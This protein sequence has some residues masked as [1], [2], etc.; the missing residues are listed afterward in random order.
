MKRK[1]LVRFELLVLAAVTLLLA[2]RVLE[3]PPSPSGI[4]VYDDLERDDLRRESFSIDAPVRVAIEAIGSFETGDDDDEPRLAA[5]G[6]LLNRLDRTVAWKLDPERAHRDRNTLAVTMDTVLLAPGTYDTY[7]TSY[8]NQRSGGFNFRLFDTIFGE[9]QAWKDDAGK[10]KMIVRRA[11]GQPAAI[12]AIDSESA[13]ELSPKGAGLIWSSAP[14]GGREQAEFVFRANERVPLRI[15]AVGEI[16]EDTQMDY[17][18]IENAVTHDRAWEMT[19][20]NTV[21]AGGWDVNR[22]FDASIHVD[23]GIYKAVFQTDPRQ[24]FEDWVGNP[25]YDPAGWGLSLFTSTPGALAEYNPWVDREPIIQIKEVGDDQRRSAQFRVT[26]PVQLAAYAV[27]EMG[28]GGRYDYAWIRNNDTQETVWE[29]TYERTTP[30]GGDNNRRALAFL[31]FSEGTYTVIYETDDSHSFESWR[32]GT[33]ENPER[34]GVS[35]FPV[36]QNFDTSAVEVLGYSEEDLD[37]DERTQVHP[38]HPHPPAPTLPG[39]QIVDL[40][41]LGN[42]KRVSK[43]FTLDQP[44]TLHIR[45]LGEVS[46][47]GRYDYGWIERAEDGKIVW[48]MTWQNTRPAGGDDVNRLFEGP[49][50]LEPGTYTAHFKTDFSHAYGDFDDETPAMPEAWGISIS[51]P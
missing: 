43:E 50:H 16:D 37:S 22:L 46:L 9:D 44:T 15:Y 24:D 12:Q 47:S 4:V 33:P 32:H 30:A 17:G 11:D 7:F 8:G 27:G 14:M 35:L 25:P 28:D 29:M 19:L 26:Q 36:A 13:E 34:W 5:Y 49:I 6:W 18:W 23:P 51:K 38:E 39:T 40:T 21:P 20:S 45:A 1:K 48:E 42:E 10:W 2:Y 3:G 41:A 31:E